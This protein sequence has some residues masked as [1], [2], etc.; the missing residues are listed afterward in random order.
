MGTCTTLFYCIFFSDSLKMGKAPHTKDAEK[1]SIVNWLQIS[2]N[3]NLI[4]GAV[5]STTVV[6]GK[7]LKRTDGYEAL[8]KYVN[9]TCNSG[10]DTKIAKSRFEA[11]KKTYTQTVRASCQTGFGVTAADKAK[12]IDTVEKKLENMCTNFSQM[13]RLFGDRQNVVPT[14][15]HQSVFETDSEPESTESFHFL[16]TQPQANTENPF[17]FGVSLENM[18]QYADVDEFNVDESYGEEK[19]LPKPREAIISLKKRKRTLTDEEVKRRS[20][21]PSIVTQSKKKDLSTSY[22]EAQEMRMEKEYMELEMTQKKYDVDM[23]VKKEELEIKKEELALKKE[24][25]ILQTRAADMETFKELSKVLI[26]KGKTGAEIK[27]F[28]D[29]LLPNR[30][31]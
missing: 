29:E 22:F 24:Q 1:L 20:S 23:A 8:A 15:V 31:Q 17:Q 25:L 6:A 10:W 27:A 2:S 26:E 9:Q 16:S 14:H 18:S 13:D 21:T 11:Y 19:P 5:A 3:F 12:G 7:K 4:N 30:S 28:L